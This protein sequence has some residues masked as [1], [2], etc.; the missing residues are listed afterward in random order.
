MLLFQFLK[1]LIPDNNI[2]LEPFKKLIEKKLKF[3]YIDKIKKLTP[4]YFDPFINFLSMLENKIF[5]IFLIT[6]FIIVF[7][8]S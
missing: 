7:M 3:L 5:L 8:V 1:D 6:I 2:N 4:I